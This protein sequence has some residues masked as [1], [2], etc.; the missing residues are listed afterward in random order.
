MLDEGFLH[1]LIMLG[2][3]S[4]AKKSAS[5]AKAKPDKSAALDAD[6]EKGAS[7]QRPADSGFGDFLD[8]EIQDFRKQRTE[9]LQSWTKGRG[10]ESVFHATASPQMPSPPPVSTVL[11]LIGFLNLVSPVWKR[12]A[13]TIS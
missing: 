3:A 9:R 7:K 4:K 8:G 6:V 12:I 13:N 10:I 5:S 2:L 1:I 11:P